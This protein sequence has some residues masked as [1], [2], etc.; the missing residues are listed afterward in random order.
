MSRHPS[1]MNPT[2]VSTAS[3]AD[4]LRI[5]MQTGEVQNHAE[6]HLDLATGNARGM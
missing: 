1:M 6:H 2:D 4:R 3:F 5:A